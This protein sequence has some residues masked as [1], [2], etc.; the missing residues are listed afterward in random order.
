MRNSYC[1]SLLLFF[2][3]CPYL[4][5]GSPITVQPL[6]TESLWKPHEFSGTELSSIQTHTSLFQQ[7]E[8]LKI[9]NTGHLLVHRGPKNTTKLPEIPNGRLRL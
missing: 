2:S 9:P 1:G 6:K 8:S 3:C 5:F 4:Y 7:P